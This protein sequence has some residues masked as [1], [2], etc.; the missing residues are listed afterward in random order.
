MRVELALIANQQGGLITRDQAVRA[1]YAERELRTLTAVHGPWVAVRRGVYAKRSTIECAQGTRDGM[2]RLEDRAA[3]L[4]MH[5]P[6]VMSHDSA[7]R[8][9]GIPLMRS[10]RPLIHV[11]RDGVLG[12]RTE[13]GVKHHLT[14]IDLTNTVDIFGMRV[15]GMARTALDLAREHGREA[16]TVAVDAVRRRGISLLELRSEVATM[17]SWPHVKDARDAIALSD[18]GAETPGE[19]LLRLALSDAAIGEI[20]TQVPL[21]LRSRTAWADCVIG[22]HVFE[23]D[24]RTKFRRI[25]DGGVA[26]SVE[27]ALWDERQRHNEI[28]EQDLGI[29]RVTWDELLGSNRAPTIARLKREY[30]VTVRRFGHTMPTAQAEFGSAMVMERSRR[31][32]ADYRGPVAG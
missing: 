22:R 4:A 9:H 1:G 24:G 14:R 19:T 6:H 28:L 31:L 29:S 12:T 2:A 32:R 25:E 10:R 16:G 5:R 26:K 30:A 21:R 17:N 18:P 27:D 8:A 11:T 23:F 20:T 3:H 15:T 7:A 13:A